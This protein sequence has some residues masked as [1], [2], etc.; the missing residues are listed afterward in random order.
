MPL[1]HA[2]GVPVF[3]VS[4]SF[5]WRYLKSSTNLFGIEFYVPKVKIDVK[6]FL[7]QIITCQKLKLYLTKYR[8]GDT[9]SIFE[10]YTL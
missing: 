8:S 1:F 4:R 3:L 2:D 10:T 5:V 9:E 7:Y 6:K